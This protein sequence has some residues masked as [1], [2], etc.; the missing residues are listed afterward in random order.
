MHRMNRT[1]NTPIRAGTRKGKG[2]DLVEKFV[3]IVTLLTKDWGSPV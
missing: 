1:T 3:V 2:F